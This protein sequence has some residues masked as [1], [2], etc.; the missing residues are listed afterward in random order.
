MSHTFANFIVGPSNHLA[1]AAA[2]TV[3]KAPGTVYNPLVIYGGTGLGKTHLL[4][5]MFAYIQQQ[6]PRR[7]AVY[8]PAT[9]LSREVG[10][11]GLLAAD[12]FL[13]DDGQ[14]LLE[15]DHGREIFLHALQ[16]LYEGE[17][18]LIVSLN[19]SPQALTPEDMRLHSRFTSGLV[20]EI[21]P[22]ALE[23][24]LAILHAKACESGISLSQHVATLLA[25]SLHHNIRDLE[26]GLARLVTYA[27]LRARHIDEELV[28][29]VLQHLQTES[30]HF[31]T[32]AQIQQMVAKRFGLT[33]RALQSRKRHQAVTLPRQ[34]AMFLCRDLTNTAL[35]EIGQHFGGRNASTVLHACGK[36]V[37][38]QESNEEV[39]QLLWELRHALQ[40]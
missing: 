3:A 36:V 8:M 10:Q 37:H 39:A 25:S 29:T 30:Q 34:V 2:M 5:A 6:A 20:A 4:Q 16:A 12:M 28:Y 1:Y 19:R 9:R 26:N 27:S 15:R 21:Q 35:P 40:R 11:G 32:V 13:I 38:M 31:V 24:R 33:V 22:P 14:F 17:K 18:Q 23:T 7:R